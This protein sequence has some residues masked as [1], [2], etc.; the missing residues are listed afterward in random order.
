VGVLETHCSN[1]PK[2]QYSL[3]LPPGSESPQQ[4]QN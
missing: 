4:K 1:Y 3:L 2:F